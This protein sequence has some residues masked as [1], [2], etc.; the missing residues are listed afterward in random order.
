M[1]I[2]N[3]EITDEKQKKE[4]TS[5]YVTLENQATVI[6]S[7]IRFVNNKIES[8]NKVKL[9]PETNEILTILTGFKKSIEG[10]ISS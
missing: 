2:I 8:R 10:S 6:R 4:L 1:E 9:L 3:E 5:H 7:K